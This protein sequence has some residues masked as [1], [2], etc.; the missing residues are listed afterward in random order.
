MEFEQILFNY[1]LYQYTGGWN[2]ADC[3]HFLHTGTMIEVGNY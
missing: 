2:V 3:N 1:V